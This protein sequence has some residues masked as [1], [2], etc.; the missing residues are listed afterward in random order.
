MFKKLRGMNR[1][2]WIRFFG[3][4]LNGI[5]FMMLQPFFALY[6]ADKV[7]SLIYVGIVMAISPIFSIFG[8]MIGGKL[9]DLY[10][11]RPIM[12]WSMLGN[13]IVMLGFVFFDTFIM[14]AVL[15]ALL[16]FFNSLFHPAASAMVADVTTPEQRNEAFGLLRMGH[17]I[18][19]AI[20]P[21]LG[22][23]II[24]FSKSIIFLITASTVT[25]YAF[26]VF[27]FIKE[28]LPKSELVKEHAKQSTEKIP[29]P[30]SV[31]W[32][33]RLLLVF[34]LTGVVISMSFSQT[35]GMLPIHFDIEMKHLP[36]T[37]NP[38]PYLLA[39]NGLLVVLFQF[40]IA[41]WSGK[42][43]IGAVMLWGSILFGLGQIGIALLP[44][45]FYEAKLDFLPILILLL[46]V[47]A[48]YTLGEMLI[49]P[50]QMT[51]ISN[52][53][54][55]HLRGT[56]MGAAGLQWIIGGAVGPII[57]GYLLNKELGDIM[58]TALGIGCMIAGVVYLNI[59]KYL[60][61]NTTTHPSLST[62]V[63]NQNG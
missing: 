1:N 9:A 46:V 41:S 24:F 61:P 19:A 63:D 23:S 60:M 62:S 30:F 59:N 48:V 49:T 18:G 51:F 6:L 55:D 54:P 52:I 36:E 39:F 28:T 42:F 50:V 32:K 31:L 29:S 45:T 17:N 4:S 27:I 43:R 10:G 21:L 15:S 53:A 58:F 47:Y 35:E 8:T 26:I 40:P 3:E 7:D 25:F 56:Y 34:V 13:G 44:S 57:S 37:L 16:G 12:I 33:D 20:G 5:A 22:A 14:F 38:F 2:V 11:R